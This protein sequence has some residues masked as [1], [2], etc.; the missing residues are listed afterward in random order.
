[1]TI[2]ISNVR[3][4]HLDQNSV[5]R[6][7]LQK[8]IVEESFPTKP[9]G[10]PFILGSQRASVNT[11]VN[12]GIGMIHFLPARSTLGHNARKDDPLSSY[13]PNDTVNLTFALIRSMR[14][15]FLLDS[16]HH[17]VLQFKN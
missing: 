17:S 2:F 14:L 3:C 11:T 5:L 16:T 1:M 13:F 12:D 8:V 15:V 7:H 9:Y 4:C 10:C 6:H